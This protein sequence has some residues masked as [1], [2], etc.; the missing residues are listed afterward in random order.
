MGRL[1]V[2]VAAALLLASVA[3]CEEGIEL[4]PGYFF[5][6]NCDSEQPECCE[7][8]AGLPFCCPESLWMLMKGGSSMAK[9]A[10]LT[11]LDGEYRNRESPCL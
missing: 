6:V 2:T 1:G 9:M 3:V 7:N 11:G 8:S 4:Q 5:C 10:E